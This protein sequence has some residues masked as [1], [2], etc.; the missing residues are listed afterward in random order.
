MEVR[1]FRQ[2]RGNGVGELGKDY[3][4]ERFLLLVHREINLFLHLSLSNKKNYITGA[5]VESCSHGLI[6]TISIINS[7]PKQSRHEPIP[8]HTIM[9]HNLKR[10]HSPSPPPIKE[11][12]KSSIIEDRQ[13]KFLALYSPTPTIPPS[14][15]LTHPSTAGATH[16][17]AAWRKPSPQRSL[18]TSAPLLESSYD[19]D[20]EKYGGKAILQVLE[21]LDVQG[22]VVVARWWG[23]VM[24]GPVR[25]EHIR[26]CAKAAILGW[27]DGNEDEGEG[28]RKKVQVEEEQRG[29]LEQ[30]LRER[31]ESIVVLRGL[32]AEKKGRGGSSQGSQSGSPAKVMDYGKLPLQALK[33]LE[34]VRD[35]TIGWIL[36]SIEEA[37]KQSEQG[38]IVHEATKQDKTTSNFEEAAKQDGKTNDEKEAAKQGEKRHD[39]KEAEN[40]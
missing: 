17:I 5:R 40:G 28:K 31:D 3:V 21:A 32:L 15:L 13:S 29:K 25:F 7:N 14:T 9:S 11:I 26:N 12:F 20:G 23:G 30:T 8:P 4:S 24:L 34:D 10:A 1:K 22:V 19:D 33:R 38:G 16:R 37:E 36:K 35:A 6:Q 39:K 27:R 2:C 18:K